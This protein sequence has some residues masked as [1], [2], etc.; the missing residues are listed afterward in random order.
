MELELTDKEKELIEAI[1]NLKNSNHNY[2][3]E[4]ELYV[5]QLFEELIDED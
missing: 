2:S 3:Q 5:R 1:R 4:L